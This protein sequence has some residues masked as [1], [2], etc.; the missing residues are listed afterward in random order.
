MSHLIIYLFQAALQIITLTIKDKQLIFILLQDIALG[1]LCLLC[2]LFV[3]NLYVVSLMSIR[4]LFLNA[5]CLL[6]G[7]PSTIFGFL[8]DLPR[9]NRQ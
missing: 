5:K 1:D 7:V 9:E 4:L 6:Q 3:Y 2:L 8:A